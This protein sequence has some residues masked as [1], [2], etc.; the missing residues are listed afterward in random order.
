MSEFYKAFKHITNNTTKEKRKKKSEQ[1][2]KNSKL[3][4]KDVP[5]AI[6]IPG[7]DSLEYMGENILCS[8]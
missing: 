5:V 2:Q 6:T 1:Q 7:D 8:W 4:R 3:R